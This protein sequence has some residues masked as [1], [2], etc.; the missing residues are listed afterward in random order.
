[1]SAD[2]AIP[3]KND[4]ATIEWSP[5]HEN[6]I[7]VIRFKNPWVFSLL[8]VDD[9]KQLVDRFHAQKNNTIKQKACI[10]YAQPVMAQRRNIFV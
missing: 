5:N 8:E 7:A 4:T 10:F 2:T 1:M 6:E 3:A 9:F